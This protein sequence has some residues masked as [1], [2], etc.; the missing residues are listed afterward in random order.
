MGL[1]QPEQHFRCEPQSAIGQRPEQYLGTLAAGEHRALEPAE[2]LYTSPIFEKA[3]QVK[4]AMEP[5][6]TTRWS[7]SLV[8][9]AVR[10]LLGGKPNS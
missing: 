8:G 4:G 2:Q 10:K 7:G 9:K 1:Q 3:N 5:E 6:F